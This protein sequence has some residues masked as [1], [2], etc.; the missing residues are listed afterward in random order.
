MKFQINKSKVFSIKIRG[1]V[2]EINHYYFH[3]SR[4]K[5]KK[6]YSTNHISLFSHIY[7]MG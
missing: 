7:I 5:I 3:H 6:K 4:E 1:E 2:N